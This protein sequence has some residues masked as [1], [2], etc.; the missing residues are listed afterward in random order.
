MRLGWVLSLLN[1]NTHFTCDFGPRDH[2]QAWW[3]DEYE[4]DLGKPRGNYYKDGNVYFREFEKGI[5]AASPHTRTTITLN[6]EYVELTTGEQAV[7][8]V[9]DKGEGRIFLKKT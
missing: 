4:A 7:S 1:D 3:F 9:I 2:G 6:P 5:V 8:F